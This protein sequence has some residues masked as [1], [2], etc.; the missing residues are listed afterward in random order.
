MGVM[1]GL[2][3]VVVSVLGPVIFDGLNI[4]FNFVV[5]VINALPW[6]IAAVVFIAAAMAADGLSISLLDCF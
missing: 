6:F 5:F 3:L 2:A 1:V 4:G